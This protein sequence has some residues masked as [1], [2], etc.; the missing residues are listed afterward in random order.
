MDDPHGLL[1]LVM[2][3]RILRR[4][5]QARHVDAEQGPPTALRLARDA[6]L[7]ARLRRSV[8]SPRPGASH[9]ALMTR[10]RKSIAH[11]D[12]E[13]TPDVEAGPATLAHANMPP[14]STLPSTSFDPRSWPP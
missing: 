4:R 6:V 5:R 11:H 3:G 1:A 14:M 13:P 7:A 8:A 10:L 2:L 9:T 12:V